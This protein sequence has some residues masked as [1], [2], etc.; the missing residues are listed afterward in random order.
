MARSLRPMLR[1]VKYY[2]LTFVAGN[3]SAGIRFV[4]FYY[5]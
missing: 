2:L 5:Y 4:E 3:P 1:I